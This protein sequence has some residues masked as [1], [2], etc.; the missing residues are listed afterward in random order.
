VLRAFGFY[1]GVSLF[2]RWLCQA[3]HGSPRTTLLSKF[4]LDRELPEL[5]PPNHAAQHHNT[6][7]KWVLISTGIMFETGT[8]V[9]DIPRRVS[10]LRWRAAVLWTQ[11]DFRVCGH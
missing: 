9:C 4:Q 2:R 3:A 7:S 10:A 11:H 6:R 5:H 1:R 8:A